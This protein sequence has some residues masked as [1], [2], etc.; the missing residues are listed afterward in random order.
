M[1]GP[2]R[3][4][5]D[6]ARPALDALRAAAR[7][8][9]GAEP[10]G[11]LRVAAPPGFAA[12]WMIPRLESFRNAHP[13]IRLTLVA[14]EDAAAEVS[15]LFAI[16]E[17]APADALFLM[18]PAFFPVAAPVLAQRAGGL[19]RVSALRGLTFL[20]LGDRKDW[21]LWAAACGAPADMIADAARDGREMIFGDVALLVA[22]ARAGL[23]VALGDAATASAALRSG[24]LTR[25]L[26]AEAPA[27]RGYH[28][29]IQPGAGR[30]AMLF[31]DWLRRAL[32]GP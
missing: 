23:G 29:R 18:K 15:I 4:F 13:G 9:G 24:A 22:A 2:A 20:H 21:S 3:R 7:R 27:E 30:A 5:L 11:P 17:E 10:A 12:S 16:P 26:A 19:R 8:A 28:L 14:G 25:P 31:A 6:E 1:T 32:T